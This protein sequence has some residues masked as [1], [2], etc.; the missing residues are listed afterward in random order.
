MNS[1]DSV[2]DYTFYRKDVRSEHLEKDMKGLS[3]VVLAGIAAF[4]APS[5]AGNTAPYKAADTLS[6]G[7]G[8]A[9]P[10]WLRRSTYMVDKSVRTQAGRRFQTIDQI[11]AAQ[12]AAQGIS[13]GKTGVATP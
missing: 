13:K 1:I 3:I 8:G 2:A 12:K 9:L 5:F 4:A 10:L 11:R 6:T 7:Q